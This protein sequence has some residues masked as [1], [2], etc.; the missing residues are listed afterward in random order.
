MPKVS[1]VLVVDDESEVLRLIETLLAREGYKVIVASN[2]EKALDK[3]RK[4]GSAPD[5]LLT[6][7]VMP[8]LSGPMLVDQLREIYPSLKVLFMSAYDE[9]QI[10]R[11]YVKD[12]GFALIPKPFHNEELIAKVKELIEGP[13]ADRSAETA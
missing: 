4:L 7:V 5:L 8:G 2:G 11:R 12:P 13:V 10:V 1:T 3:T 6:D 9:R